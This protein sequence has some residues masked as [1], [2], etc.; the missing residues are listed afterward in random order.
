L[1]ANQQ[2]VNVEFDIS[3]SS[4]S[5]LQ[6][7]MGGS[8]GGSGGAG[9]GKGTLSMIT[10]LSGIAIGVVGLVSL[11]KKITSLMVD[12]SPMLQQVLKIFNTAIMFI[13]RPIGDFIGF[14]LR[15]IMV[16]FLRTIALP[17]YKDAM[18]ALRKLGNLLGHDLLKGL[19]KG[20][21]GKPGKNALEEGFGIEDMG[22]NLA[23][24]MGVVLGFIAEYIDDIKIVGSEF[25]VIAG[26][27]IDYFGKKKEDVEKKIQIILSIIDDVST[28]L[29]TAWTAIETAI[30]TISTGIAGVKTTVTNTITS[31]TTTIDSIKTKFSTVKGTIDVIWGL[32]TSPIFG[33]IGQLNSL[34]ILIIKPIVDGFTDFTFPD[35]PQILTDM[36][37]EWTLPDVGKMIEDFVKELLK[38]PLGIGKSIDEGVN[39]VKQDVNITLDVNGDGVVDM[40]DANDFIG[41]IMNQLNQGNP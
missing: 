2:T 30:T 17:F 38:D 9:G 24:N 27:V 33:V 3:S 11:V 1:S 23:F 34:Y 41:N 7:I 12:S 26:W 31:I 15:P 39:K 37:A 21:E 25:I 4:L 5:K 19:T 14:F 18:P 13:F 10:K 22:A 20:A 32:I 28:E 36:V 35:I 8:K 40:N 16:Y 29:N 6:S